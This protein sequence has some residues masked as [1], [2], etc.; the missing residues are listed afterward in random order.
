MHINI[1]NLFKLENPLLLPLLLVLKHASNK[2]VSEKVASLV[3]ED[4]NIEYLLQNDYIKYIKGKKNQN[5]FERMRLG[6]KGTK[7]LNDLDEPMVED[8][9]LM[10]FDWLSDIYK[11]R[12]K[13]IGNG[14]KTKRLIASFREK[15]GIEKN[16]LAFLCRTFIEDENEQEYSHRLEYVFWKPANVFQTK[17]N[18][19]DSRLWKYYNKQ[20]Q[21]FDQQFKKL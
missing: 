3:M 19:E 16:K 11:K 9:D 18:L 4:D 14:K 7:F 20:K 2:D 15:S 21:F 12:Q 6:K 8:Q 17:F 10:I 5:E 13:E 1:D